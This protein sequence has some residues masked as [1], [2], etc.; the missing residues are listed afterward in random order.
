M[1]P[2]LQEQHLLPAL[3]LWHADCQVQAN[4]AERPLQVGGGP[5]LVLHSFASDDA[6]TSGS[7]TPRQSGL[8]NFLPPT[9]ARLQRLRWSAALTVAARRVL[10][11]FSATPGASLP[12]QRDLHYGKCC[13]LKA[14]MPCLAMRARWNPSW[15]RPAFAST[16]VS[17]GKGTCACAACY[18]L[19]ISA[20][21]GLG[22]SG[23]QPMQAVMAHQC[24]ARPGLLGRHLRDATLL[25]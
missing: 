3:F 14:I 15:G 8:P 25:L 9:H 6:A 21:C 10:S 11:S 17:S 23:V 18:C 20:W 7:G 22:S 12:L 2:R 4:H 16:P 19:L 1:T 13:F 5:H 24:G